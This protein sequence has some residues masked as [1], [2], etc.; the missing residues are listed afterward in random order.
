MLGFHLMLK[1]LLMLYL[2]HTLY[3]YLLVFV[4]NTVT[5]VVFLFIFTTC[6][7]LVFIFM[8]VEKSI[9]VQADFKFESVIKTCCP[10]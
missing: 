4:L 6:S 1:T 9:C 2:M 3:I 10:S 8:S 5:H 7:K